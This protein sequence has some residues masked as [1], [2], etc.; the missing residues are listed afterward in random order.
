LADFCLEYSEE[1]KEWHSESNYIIILSVK[2]EQCLCDFSQTLSCS[3]IN[4][5][6]FREPDIG[7]EITALAIC[8]GPQ[9]KKLCQ[10][11]PLALRNIKGQVA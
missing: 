1:A 7:N 3:G 10:H 6:I 5:S 9:V 2:T 4:H 8:P 11:L